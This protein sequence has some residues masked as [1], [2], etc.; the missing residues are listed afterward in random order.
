[1]WESD[2]LIQS[3][4]WKAIPQAVHPLQF[5]FHLK[6]GKD[7][8]VFQKSVIRGQAIP[9]NLEQQNLEI[10]HTAMYRFVSVKVCF[11]LEISQWSWIFGHFTQM[12]FSSYC[13]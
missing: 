7:K 11:R 2:D 9:W 1:M 13:Q 10:L 12:V 4:L 3:V 6:E 5:C 8:M